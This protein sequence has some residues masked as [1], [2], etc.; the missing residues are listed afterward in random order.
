MSGW[1]NWLSNVW[2]S[3]GRAGDVADSEDK[4]GD[5]DA[6]GVADTA[7]AEDKVASSSRYDGD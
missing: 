4:A 6:A 3:R 7:E 2:S 1:P 5:K